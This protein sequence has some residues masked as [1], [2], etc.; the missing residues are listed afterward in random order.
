[1]ARM[2]I[3]QRLADK[4]HENM[5][6]MDFDAVRFS[7]YLTNCGTTTQKALFEVVKGLITYWAFHNETGE[8]K[9][10]SPEYI[11]LTKNA[12]ALQTFLINRGMMD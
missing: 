3:E 9:G 6:R 4:V 11:Q 1:M 8:T 7:F 12:K 5:Q 2:G 10:N